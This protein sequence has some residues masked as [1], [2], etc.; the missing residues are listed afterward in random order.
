[1]LQMSQLAL[2]RPILLYAKT[3]EEEGTLVLSVYFCSENQVR[4]L[5][6]PIKVKDYSRR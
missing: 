1:M 4:N 5:G 3:S 6:E 2:R